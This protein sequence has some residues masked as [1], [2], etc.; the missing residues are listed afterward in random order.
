MVRLGKKVK[1]S[2][3]LKPSQEEAD[4]AARLE[5]EAL[6]E[7]RKKEAL[8]AKK[9]IKAM[10]ERELGFTKTNRL[11]I[12]NQWRKIMRLAKVESLRKEIEIL[13][14]NH[15]RD[16]DRKDAIIQMLDRDLEEAEEQ[17]QM[18][19]RAHLQNIDALIDLQDSRL[20][21]L[22]NEF[23]NDLRTLEDEFNAE[24]EEIIT[25]HNMEKTELMDIMAAV[26]AD[27]QERA[28]EAKT[29][30]ETLREEIR[31]RNLED[32]NVLRITLES[33]IEELERHFEAAHLHYLTNTDQ[34]TQDFKYLT[35][36]DQNLS[37]DIETKILKIERLQLTL[38]HWRT[39]IATNNKECSQRNKALRE[40]KN[41]IS[42]HFQSLKARMNKFR[43]GE[44]QRLL[45]LTQNAHKT[46][47]ALNKK[48]KLAS[49]IIHRAEMSRKLET[50]RE[51]VLPFYESTPL[52]D[53]M[54]RED[55]Q[56]EMET[57]NQEL[58]KLMAGAGKTDEDADPI[59]VDPEINSQGY[60]GDKNVEEW[61]YLENF[62]KKSNKA[63]LDKL[64]VERQRDRLRKENADLQSILKQYL[65]GISVNEEVLKK[66]NPLL[67]VNGRVN[68]NAPPV[69]VGGVPTRIDGNHMVNTGRSGN[70]GGR[71]Y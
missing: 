37:K 36:Q 50:E 14:Q 70:R 26:E 33:N 2:A 40:E 59:N 23:E 53:E 16:V 48:L 69:Q 10:M 25:Q 8:H 9:R 11:K 57:Q 22:E 68:L 15:E 58:R 34:R 3:K 43:D 54:K 5:R 19:L 24:R 63:L 47:G 29:E 55:E 18:A 21:A 71:L 41:A 1:G 6:M 35:T 65:D 49:E 17:Y 51:K 42:R 20:L 4:L 66:P 31:N 61:D 32:I 56:E 46:K 44:K 52:E 28:Q 30:H 12:Q 38:Q 27:E 7:L 62:F 45:E 60:N 67:V 64:A 39:K 13:S